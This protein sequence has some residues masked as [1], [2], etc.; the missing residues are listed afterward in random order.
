M[1]FLLLTALLA[2]PPITLPIEVAG[3]NGISAS[4]DVA[5]SLAIATQAKALR[6]K[7][8]GLAYPDMIGVRINNSAWT[9][10][11]N[12]SVSVAEPGKS[13][14]GIGGGFATLEITLP[15]PSGTVKDQN[16]IQFRFNRTDGLVSGFRVLAFNFVDGAGRPLLPPETFAH[17]DPGKWRPPLPNA[18]QIAAGQSLWRTAQLL[19]NGLPHSPP[20]RAHCADC[21]TRDGR[22]LKY[23]NF[24]NGSIIA[25][26]EFHGLSELQGREI[27]SYIR[28]LKVP[29]PGRPWDPPFQPGPGLDAQPSVNWAA[30]AGLTFVLDDDAEALT[31]VFN[32]KSPSAETFRPDGDLNAREI[33]IAMQ[34]PDWN[35]WLPRVHPMDAWGERFDRSKFAT[36]YEIPSGSMSDLSSF[37]TE[38]LHER[39]KFLTHLAVASP[40]WTPALGNAYYSTQL[41]QLVKTW[42][43]VQSDDYRHG[44]TRA[45]PNVIPSATAPSDTHI[46]DGPSGMGGSALTNEYYSNAWYELQIILNNGN[47]QHHDRAPVDWIYVIGHLLDLERQS[48]RPEPGRLLVAII[49]AIQSTD[50]NLG[51]TNIAEG[52]RPDQNIDPRIM[53]SEKWASEFRSLP[54]DLRSSLTEAFLSAWLDK[55]LRYPT[56]S[57]FQ[58]GLQGSFY[59]VPNEFLDISGGNVWK[60]V[61]HFRE[62]GVSAKNLSRVEAWGKAS[63]AMSQ[64]FHY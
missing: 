58:R 49:K 62:A 57:Y 31:F 39:D 51:P 59:K 54:D 22:D 25:R 18:D 29:N 60:A 41:W 11:N 46:P 56:V 27:A 10:I 48:D 12:A 64:L 45:W 32:N 17:E 5:L 14:G 34:L 50:P 52:W 2:S 1:Y 61:A 63:N 33:P 16:T 43:I 7:I 24:S 26:S 42:E 30:G 9:D 36:A 47:H 15:L 19:A 53:I 21:H 20:I 40:K 13:Y 55:T 44:A 23:F 28:S 6:M 3:P 8:H 37:F 4:V 35:H 38:W